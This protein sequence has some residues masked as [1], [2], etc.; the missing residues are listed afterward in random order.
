MGTLIDRG[1]IAF[2]QHQYGHTPAPNG[3]YFIAFADRQFQKH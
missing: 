1:D 3:P 2:R